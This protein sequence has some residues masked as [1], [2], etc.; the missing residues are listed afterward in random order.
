MIKLLWCVLVLNITLGLAAC[1]GATNDPATSGSVTSGTAITSSIAT[2]S[3]TTGTSTTNS[4][5]ASTATTSSVGTG[6]VTRP[7]TPTPPPK[8]EIRTP[9]PLLAIGQDIGS[10]NDYVVGMGKT[11]APGAVVGY[12]DMYLNGLEKTVDWGAGRGNISELARTYPNSALVV[13]VYAVDTLDTINAGSA[14]DTITLMIN[15]LKSYNRPVYLRFGYEFDGNWNNYDP[16]A[17]K[18]AFTRIKNR[19][20]ALSANKQIAMVWQSSTYCYD[21]NID[22]LGGRDFADWYPGDNFVDFVAV[23]FFTPSA[24]SDTTNGTCGVNNEAV[25]K[26]A[27]FARTHNKP[28]MIAE[29]TPYGYTTEARTWRGNPVTDAQIAVW[30]KD[31][32][33]WIDQNNVRIV[34]YINAN[35][36]K[37]R[38]WEAGGVWGDSRVEANSTIKSLWE[39]ATSSYLKADTSKLYDILGYGTPGLTGSYAGEKTLTVKARGTSGEE[40]IKLQVNGQTIKAWTLST[41]M[42]NY[43]FSTKL[44]G[45][46]TVLFD[47]DDVGRDVQVESLTVNNQVRM[48]TD[49]VNNTGAFQ[50][51]ACGGGSGRSQW[52]HCNGAINFGN[53]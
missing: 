47:N 50:N 17:Y 10:I 40:S 9:G 3:I 22:T 8:V 43:T 28:L 11:Q 53:L 2:N 7:S 13:A 52:L 46:V 1:G 31:Y 23:S 37:Q 44:A 33:A 12:I 26:L 20:D 38:M 39:K 32:F 15:T 6:P 36:N 45:D 16:K 42:T 49:Q 19:I 24:R 4:V 41:T 30:Y 27:S 51:N 34:T 48:A 29:A 18:A 21:G 25:D 35:W 14:D 5:T